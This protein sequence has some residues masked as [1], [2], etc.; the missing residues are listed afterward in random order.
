MPSSAALAS[1]FVSDTGELTFDRARRTLM[2]AAPL[3]AG[4]LGEIGRSSINAGAFD[5]QLG[6]TARGFASILLTSLDSNPLVSSSRMLLTIPGY[7]LRSLPNSTLPQQIR[8][9]PGTTD[10]WT[11]ESSNNRPSG[12]LNGG[13]GPTYLEKVEAYLTLRTRAMSIRVTALDGAGNPLS[14]ITPVEAVDGGFRIHLNANSPWHMITAE[15]P[16]PLR[17]IR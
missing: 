4:V 11:I 7:S 2:I 16:V 3:A 13:N 5:V 8:N 10:W 12:N 15:Q 14:D 17:R 9:Y 1:P 6:P